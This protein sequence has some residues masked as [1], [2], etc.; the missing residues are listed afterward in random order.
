M[1]NA[2]KISKNE[3]CKGKGGGVGF[4]NPNFLREKRPL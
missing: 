1:K 4:V 2:A 3:D